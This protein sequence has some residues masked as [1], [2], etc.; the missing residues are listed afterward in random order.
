MH[1]H[2]RVAAFLEWQQEISAD[3]WLPVLRLADDR[4]DRRKLF[5]WC[6]TH[7]PDLVLSPLDMRTEIEHVAASLDRPIHFFHLGMSRREPARETI[8]GL[9]NPA[10]EVGAA[11]V[12]ML[13]GLVYRDETGIPEYPALVEVPNTGPDAFVRNA[14]PARSESHP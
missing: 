4:T 13:A 3:Q 10:N 12:D 7:E 1:S 8:D 6:R 2:S 9:I 14:S 5:Q 11:A